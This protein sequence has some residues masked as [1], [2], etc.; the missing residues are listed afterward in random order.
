MLTKE[1][2]N[3]LRRHISDADYRP[4]LEIYQFLITEQGLE[5]LFQ[6]SEVTHYRTHQFSG[7]VVS[8]DLLSPFLKPGAPVTIWYEKQLQKR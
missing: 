7:V 2:T 3:D 1:V 8:W 4:Y 6:P 5:I